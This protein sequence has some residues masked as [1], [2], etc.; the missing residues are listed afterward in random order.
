MKERGT[1]LFLSGKKEAK[2]PLKGWIVFS[3]TLLTLHLQIL[4]QGERRNC[5]IILL[6]PFEKQTA[7]NDFGFLSHCMLWYG[8]FIKPS[9]RF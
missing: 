2:K 8:D 9:K 5:V 7:R 6:I 1:L 4:G 3:K